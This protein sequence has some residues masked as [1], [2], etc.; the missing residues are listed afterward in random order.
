MTPGW[1][2]GFTNQWVAGDSPIDCQTVPKPAG[3]LGMQT[4][5]EGTVAIDRPGVIGRSDLARRAGMQYA[6]LT[7]KHHEGVPDAV[8]TVGLLEQPVEPQ[9]EAQPSRPHHS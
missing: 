2:R 4:V 5:A 9:Q 7:A 1:P 8:D 3:H 6:V